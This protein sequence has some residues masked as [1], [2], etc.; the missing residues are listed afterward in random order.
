MLIK[1][2]INEL[3][4]Y[5]NWVYFF[6]AWKVRPGSD[7]A[8]GLKIEAE[9]MLHALNAHYSVRAV[10]ELFKCNSLGDDIIL[11]HPTNCS[12]CKMNPRMIGRLPMLRQQVASKED[13]VCYCL[14]DFIR[15]I[16][17]GI[18]DTIGV[19]AA[20]VPAAM[21]NLY[22]DDPY[23]QML[24]QTLS[25]RLAEAAAEV[26]HADVRKR[27]WGYAQDEDLSVEE[28]HME[29]YQGIRPAVGYPC[30]PDIS[31]NFVLDE[32]VPFSQIGVELTENGMMYPHASVSGLMM[33]HPSSRYFDVG[34]ITNEQLEDYAKRCG[35]T[36][37]EIRKYLSRNVKEE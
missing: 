2:Q 9:R 23:K 29:R 30:L 16:G 11:Q 6:F 21:Q 26:L 12:C 19:F 22:N 4:P 28:L 8:E 14:S 33:S 27:Y 36:S 37:D 25:D 18:Q 7:E 17:Q 24:V 35:K 13:G 31:L 10:V 3:E 5:I 20:S 34:Q 15:P 32:L 1:Y